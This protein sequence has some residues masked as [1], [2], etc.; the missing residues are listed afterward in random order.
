MLS[1]TNKGIIHRLGRIMIHRLAVVASNPF[2]VSR[3]GCNE[4]QPRHMLRSKEILTNVAFGR[5]G[6]ES[7]LP[8]ASHSSIACPTLIGLSWFRYR[9]QWTTTWRYLRVKRRT[10]GCCE[11][12]VNFSASI[13]SSAIEVG[14]SGCN[15]M[16]TASGMSTEQ[17]RAY[18]EACNLRVAGL[19]QIV[20][21]TIR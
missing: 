9:D 10:R 11:Y 7:L 21:C 5:H 17:R 18:D 3:S 15:R 20:Q 1:E 4:S 12:G 19:L 6:L 14:D 2:Y 13:A 8:I 16:T